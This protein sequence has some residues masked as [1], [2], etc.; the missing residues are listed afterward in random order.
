MAKLLY[1]LARMTTATTGTGTIT[2]G[3]AATSGGV[4]FLSFSA[5][6]VADGDTVTYA[7]ADTNASEIGRG[8]YTASG[9][10][11]TR[12]VLKSTNSNAAINLSGGAQVFITSAAE[13]LPAIAVGKSLT[14][15][16]ILTLAG[17]DSTTMT[18]PPASASIG[19]LYIPQAGGADKTTTYPIVLADNGFLITAN[20]ASFTTTIPANSTIAFPI[21]SVITFTN[22]HPTGVLS[23]AI[24]TDT[25]RS[26]TLGTG[27]RALAQY[28]VATILKVASTTWY[29]TG[30]GLT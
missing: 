18:F 29:I 28:G 4:T 24:T 25:L 22:L 10:S 9:T 16:N 27:T 8:V 26:A 23:I 30:N 3:S 7:I 19:Y 15:S 1:N 21:G 17:T 6:G 20:G 14:V 13:D 12:T 2:L 11:L 5:A